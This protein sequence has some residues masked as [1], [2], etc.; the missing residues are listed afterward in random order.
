MSIN[1]IMLRGAQGIQA[2]VNRSEGAAGRI[3]GGVD[4]GDFAASMVGL[5]SS[6]IQVKASANVVKAADEMLGTLIDLRA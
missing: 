4:S 5:R 1:S 3:A 6:E 2:G